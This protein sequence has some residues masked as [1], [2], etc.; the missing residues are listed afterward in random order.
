MLLRFRR[1][2][3]IV[4]LASPS[5]TA[6]IPIPLVLC[7]IQYIYGEKVVNF[8]NFWQI[9]APLILNVRD[10]FF[11]VGKT[12]IQPFQGV[13]HGDQKCRDLHEKPREMANKLICPNYVTIFQNQRC[14]G[15]F[16][17]LLPTF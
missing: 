3:K 2:R 7:N 13:F 11:Y 6:N 10:G 9:K 8:A 1:K 12:Y 14:I 5:W 17:H 16:M 4:I 15:V